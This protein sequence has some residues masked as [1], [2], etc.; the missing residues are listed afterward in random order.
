MRLMVG[1]HQVELKAT[2]GSGVACLL[3]G[4]GRGSNRRSVWH[5]ATVGRRAAARW[6]R[7]RL[8]AALRKGSAQLCSRRL[9]V[10][11]GRTWCSS[12]IHLDFMVPLPSS[13][14]TVTPEGE[15]MPL[16]LRWL[17]LTLSLPS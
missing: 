11:C 7:V 12:P 13:T 16:L 2:T 3:S 9:S 5:S 4:L 1:A 10:L 14:Y 6:E 17:H 15:I 8:W